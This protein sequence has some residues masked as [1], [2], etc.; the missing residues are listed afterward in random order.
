MHR[1]LQAPHPHRAGVAPD[2]ALLRRLGQDSGRNSGRVA[3][4]LTLPDTDD[5]PAL[6]TCECSGTPVALRVTAHLGFPQ[7]SVGPGPGHLA[8]VVG[9]PVPKAPVDENGNATPRQDKV[10][11]AALGDL[12]MQSEAPTSS[13]D[14]L[15]ELDFW[16]GVG[17]PAPSKVLALG[18]ADPLLNHTNKVAGLRA[19][20]SWAAGCRRLAVGD[21]LPTTGA[22]EAALNDARS[23]RQRAGEKPRASPTRPVRTDVDRIA[24]SREVA[25]RTHPALRVG[26]FISSGVPLSQ[27]RAS[28]GPDL[29]R[30]STNGK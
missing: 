30:R 27:R 18:C 13:M 11:R 23:D 25:G 7:L 24:P 8:S 1:T 9:A 6:F 28:A 26:H 22:A 21:D 3:P 4:D 10:G 2:R 29:N 15:P 20:A 16:G 5:V 17:L 19:M 14:G 12:W